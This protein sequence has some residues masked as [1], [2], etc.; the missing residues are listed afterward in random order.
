M[1]S[2][3]LGLG[4]TR[5]QSHSEVRIGARLWPWVRV[6]VV[7]RCGL[8]LRLQLRPDCSLGLKGD[9]S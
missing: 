2:P 4:W 6:R 9:P 8:R 3:G 7:T 1:D 5:L